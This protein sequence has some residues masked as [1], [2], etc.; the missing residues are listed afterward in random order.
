MGWATSGAALQRI[1]G[2]VDLYIK[3]TV[4][5]WLDKWKIFKDTN[6]YLPGFRSA[7]VTCSRFL[8]PPPQKKKY[9]LCW[10]IGV[11]LATDACEALYYNAMLSAPVFR[12][13]GE[14]VSI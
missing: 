14:I 9:V 8:I 2:G 6:M 7:S 5:C 10:S 3:K 11:A 4:I 1:F 13:R 12:T